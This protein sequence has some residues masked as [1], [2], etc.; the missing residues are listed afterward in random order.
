MQYLRTGDYRIRSFVRR[1]SRLTDRQLRAYEAAWPRFGLSLHDGAAPLTDLSATWPKRYLEIGFGS[2]QSLLA[3]ASLYPSVLFIGIETYKPGMGAL[4]DGVLRLGLANVR[5]YH[6]DVIDVLTHAMPD[7][8]LSGV[9]IF[10]PDPWP[11]RKHY[12]R[13]LVQSSLLT[14]L[15]PK[16]QTNASLHLATDW[17]DYAVHMRQVLQSPL[18]ASSH[19]EQDYAP[20]RS[21]FRPV[22]TRFEQRALNAGRHIYDFQ[23]DFLSV[24]SPSS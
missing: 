7:G 21:C 2:G 22:I 11:K 13:R 20:G 9:N 4:L 8:F 3:A 5:V 6:T 14:L 23:Y 1:D 12:A 24:A 16:M 15:A 18:L 17:D 10:F 19:P